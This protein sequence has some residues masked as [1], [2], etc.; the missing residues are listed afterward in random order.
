MTPLQHSPHFRWRAGMR[1]AGGGLHLQDNRRPADPNTEPDLNDPGTVGHLLDLF[2]I[3]TND[4]AA[5]VEHFGGKWVVVDQNGSIIS[6]SAL[7]PGVALQHAF[8]RLSPPA[9]AQAPDPLVDPPT[10]GPGAQVPL[11]PAT[12]PATPHTTPAKAT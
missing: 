7:C 1:Y 12:T 10:E 6:H 4:D 9:A 5:N 8:E 2:R 3:A 11:F